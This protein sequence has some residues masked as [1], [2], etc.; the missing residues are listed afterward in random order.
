MLRP[1]TLSEMN[2]VLRL[3]VDCALRLPE[4]GQQW[5]RRL[6]QQQIAAFGAGSLALVQADRSALP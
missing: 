4:R 2:N 6:H 5:M 1:V 3:W